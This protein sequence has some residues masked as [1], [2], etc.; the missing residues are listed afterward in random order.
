MNA[1]GSPPGAVAATADTRDDRGPFAPD[2][3]DWLRLLGG[4]LFAAGALVLLIRK[5]QEWSDWAVFAALM[6]PSLVLFALALAGR[7][8]WG[9]QGWQAAF[10]VFATILLLGALVQLVTATDGNPRAT[11]NL[12]WTFG[13]TGLV[14]IVTA[15]AL[16]AP[17]QMLLG[18]AALVISWLALWDKV[19]D[20]PKGNTVRWL[21]VALAAIYFVGGAL[22][23][24]ARRPQAS[25]LIAVAGFVAVIA[26]ALSFAAAS[27]AGQFGALSGDVPKPTQG[28]NVFLLVVSLALIAYG[29]RS[30]T[31]GPAYAG[32]VGLTLFIL[33]VGADLVSRLSGDKGGGVVGWPLILLIGGGAALALSFVLKPGSLG[34]PGGGAAATP[35]AP[36]VAG[37]AAPGQPPAGAPGYGQPPAAPQPPAQPG[38]QPGEPGSLLDQWR[39]QPPPGA[40]PPQQ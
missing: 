5:Q 16:R 1:F 25:D 39:Q 2:R 37:Y 8:R 34:G 17:Y 36:E 33:L 30:A 24:R 28:W 9:L 40:G 19:L 31:R 35:G 11:L 12:L 10:L 22:L 6:V 29:A 32:A 21:L 3:R 18:A 4:M 23:Q 13:V 26:G 38:P 14:A 15:F 7:A 20:N 27:A